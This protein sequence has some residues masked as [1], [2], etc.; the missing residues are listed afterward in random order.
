MRT[1]DLCCG[2]GGIRRG[3]ELAGGY[4]NVISAEIDDYACRTYTHLYGE[5]P[6][7]DVKSPEFKKKLKDISYDILLA[8]FPC[9][10]FSRVGLR[11]G[12]KDKT[13]G[14]IFFDIVEIIETT[15][16]KAVFL[17]NV[18]NLVSHDNGETF[19]T[20]LSTL[21]KELNYFVVGVRREEDGKLIYKKSDFLRNTKDFGLPQNRPRTYIIAFSR[22]H[23]GRHLEKISTELPKKGSTI[24]YNTVSDILEDTVPAGFFLAEGFLKTLEDHK[25]RQK[26]SG[27]G[28]G[29][30]VVN[31][32]G[33]ECTLACTILATGGSG[34]ERNLVYDEKNGKKYAGVVVQGKKTAINSKF[35]RYMTPVEWGKLQGFIDYAFVDENGVDKFSFPQKLSNQQKYKQF[36]NSVSVPVIREMAVFVRNCFETMEKDF[37]EEEKEWFAMR[38]SEFAVCRKIRSAL[39]NQARSETLKQ[40]YDLVLKLGISEPFATSD[41][42]QVLS[43]SGARASQIANRLLKHR[44]IIRQ[45]RGVYS[46]DCIERHVDNQEVPAEEVSE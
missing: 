46:F 40:Y 36:G 14:T 22:N 8:G 1:I 32:P 41:I 45:K 10:T 43:V 20:I 16:P 26:K 37:S 38:G 23:F 34:K 15:A 6:K 33:A 11:K 44:C 12:F 3:F 39:E 18:E 13:K 31:M 25:T 17:E 42:A 4:Q 28:F 19:K 5:N 7:N 9:Q 29:Y 35:I 24:I 27:N 21:E 30:R 2:I